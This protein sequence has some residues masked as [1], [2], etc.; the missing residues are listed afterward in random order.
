MCA[1]R[2]CVCERGV[3]AAC[4]NI[5]TIV[6]CKTVQG[7]ALLITGHGT[8]GQDPCRQSNRDGAAS[9]RQGEF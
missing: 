9:V 1:Y 7:T 6:K 5:V 8:V 4:K 2:H 3:S